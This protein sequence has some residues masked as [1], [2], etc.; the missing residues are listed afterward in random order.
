VQ[1]VPKKFSHPRRYTLSA[2]IVFANSFEIGE[3]RLDSCEF[4]AQIF[5]Q[6]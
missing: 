5:V 6:H 4:E 1:L 3:R 2:P